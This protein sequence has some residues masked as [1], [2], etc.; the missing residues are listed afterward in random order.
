MDFSARSLVM[1]IS[2]VAPRSS[3]SRRWISSTTRS[4]SSESHGVLFL[5]SESTFSEVAMMISFL[6]RFS[7]L[8]S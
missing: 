1:T 2:R 3:E 7:S 6:P 8:R 5:V 4:V